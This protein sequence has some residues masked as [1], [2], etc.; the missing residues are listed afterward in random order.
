[1]LG[2]LGTI[3][4]AEEIAATKKAMARLIARTLQD[5]VRFPVGGNGIEPPA[6][7]SLRDPLIGGYG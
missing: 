6:G 1:M 7:Y 3:T 4:K 2:R 5:T